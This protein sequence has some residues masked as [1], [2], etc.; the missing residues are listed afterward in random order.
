MLPWP[1]AGSRTHRQHGLDAQA[2]RRPPHPPHPGAWFGR[3]DSQQWWTEVVLIV[4]KAL[5]QV[6]AVLFGF[7]PTQAACPPPSL[8][9]G[10]RLPLGVWVSLALYSLPWGGGGWQCEPGS[11]KGEAV[12]SAGLAAAP[13]HDL[14]AAFSKPVSGYSLFASPHRG[15]IPPR[16]GGGRRGGTSPNDTR[17]ELPGR[18]AAG[19]RWVRFFWPN[20]DLA[21]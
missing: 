4:W 8:P 13:P 6:P 14:V 9:P 17:R 16:G 2:L 11:A 1:R 21:L 15:D 5:R 7:L 20:S 19:T 10:G 18:R 3:L 12:C